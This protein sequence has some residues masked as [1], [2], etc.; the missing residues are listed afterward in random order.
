MHWGRLLGFLLFGLLVHAG[1][2]VAYT[3]PVVRSHKA[4]RSDRAFLRAPKDIDLL[5]VG[6]SHARTAVLGPLVGP[7]VANIAFGGHDQVKTWYRTRELV[8]RGRKRVSAILVPLDAVAFSPWRVDV[9]NP[10]VVWGRYVDFLELGRVEGRPAK[11]FGNW[12]KARFFPYAGELRTLNQLRRGKFGFG[13]DLPN[14]DFSLATPS[15]REGIARRESGDHLGFEDHA[16]PLLC[17]AFESLVAWA[18]ERD[19]QVVAVA[20]PLTREYRAHLDQ[21]D[22]WEQVRT[23]VLE[24]FLADPDHVWLDHGRTFED[25]PDL[26]SDSH[27]LNERGR[28][29]FSYGLRL[30]LTNRGLLPERTEDAAF[31]PPEDEP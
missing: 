9:F 3:T 26:F 28:A 7:R 6:D 31:P 18:D 8:E 14:A 15:Q 1:L 4:V 22:A 23:Q 16:H 21:T 5:V 29:L 2:T 11:Y 27:H 24:P 30:E 12:L 13:E 19:I 10:E 25:R 20:Y 17:W